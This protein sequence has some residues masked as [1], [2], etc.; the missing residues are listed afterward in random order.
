MPGE[1]EL[2]LAPGSL[3]LARDRIQ[4]QAARLST[5]TAQYRMARERERRPLEQV[6]REVEAETAGTLRQ[7]AQMLSVM[8]GVDRA[9]S[10][11][12]GGERRVLAP[13]PAPTASVPRVPAPIRRA[14]T[15]A[16]TPAAARP[17]PTVTRPTVARRAVRPVVPGG[18]PRQIAPWL[19]G[20][21]RPSR[22]AEG[23][24][25]K[26]D[27]GRLVARL[28]GGLV[29]RG[30]RALVGEQGRERIESR[31]KGGLTMNI[32]GDFKE[33]VGTLALVRSAFTLPLL[34]YLE[35]RA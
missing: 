23:L 28:H 33:H 9:E 19:V 35:A 21:N 20:K 4:Q 25:R 1:F 15:P 27:S 22:A 16:P 30:E 8:R 18:D 2:D 11:L 26:G 32:I 3:S 7:T 12:A 6:T 34:R 14:P 10:S 5:I 31:I 29:L 24:M 13:L 17:R